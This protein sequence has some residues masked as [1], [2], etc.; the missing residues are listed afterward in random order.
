MFVTYVCTFFYVS[1]TIKTTMT[2]TNTATM[3][4]IT[5]DIIMFQCVNE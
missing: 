1:V 3:V 5:V 2:K 4:I